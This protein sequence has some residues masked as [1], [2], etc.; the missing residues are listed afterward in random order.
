MCSRKHCHDCGGIYVAFMVLCGCILGTS[1]MIAVLCISFISN[2]IESPAGISTIG[3]IL[4]DSSALFEVNTPAVAKVKFE[5]Y[6]ENA[7]FETNRIPPIITE[8]LHPQQIHISVS[9]RV[10]LVSLRYDLNYLGSYNPIYLLAGSSIQYNITIELTEGLNSEKAACLHLFDNRTSFNNFFNSNL[11]SPW[12]VTASHC[13]ASNA[14]YSYSFNITTDGVYYVGAEVSSDFTIQAKA[15]VI[16]RRYSTTGL[17]QTC[18]HSHTCTVTLCN[19]FICTDESTTYFLI[20][21]T[22]TTDM[23]HTFSGPRLR[24]SAY[25]GFIA[26]TVLGSLFCC[27]CCFLIC[28]V[29]KNIFCCCDHYDS[30]AVD[31]FFD[32][33]EGCRKKMKRRRQRFERLATN[34]P[35]DDENNVR[36]AGLRHH[37]PVAATAPSRQIQQDNNDE[38]HSRISH[39]TTG[40]V[41]SFD[42]DLRLA[43]Y[44]SSIVDTPSTNTIGED[45]ER[46]IDPPLPSL[47][48]IEEE[49]NHIELSNQLPADSDDVSLIN[50]S[51][52]DP[53]CLVELTEDID[54]PKY[55]D[56]F[57][58]EGN[59]T[60]IIEEQQQELLVQHSMTE[61]SPFDTIDHNE[62]NNLNAISAANPLN[63]VV[64]HTNETESVQ[65]VPLD[66]VLLPLPSPLEEYKTLSLHSPEVE[67]VGAVNECSNNADGDVLPQDTIEEEEGEM[68][69]LSDEDASA[70][71]PESSISSTV[72]SLPI[73]KPLPSNFKKRLNES[74]AP[75]ILSAI[76]NLVGDWDFVGLYLGIDNADL[77]RIKYKH[78]RDADRCQKE[79]IFT[80]LR[81]RNATRHKLI[82]AL[83]EAGRNDIAHKV[84]K[85]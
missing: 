84:K 44:L 59:T 79:M 73:Y 54:S 78:N 67:S 63:T 82:K 5:I 83:K 50:L 26:T 76:K 49:N 66:D 60:N 65:L 52:D 10:F 51:R 58:Q 42:E 39:E 36:P 19:T 72:E 47:V 29:V 41:D 21:P 56:V 14:T 43:L 11:N 70:Y 38:R 25:A 48:P 71:T 18:D 28:C 55:R 23:L 20:Q 40:N 9:S 45:E 1:F 33:Y 61:Q 64:I 53:A 8:D 81:R 22:N 32:C 31:A 37:R 35:D 7:I 13:F 3:D 2:V 16:R 57:N 6:Y 15:S 12:Q 27:C 4:H 69:S 74:H 85:L 80:W 68:Q 24:G 34:D 75:I 30:D 17:K 77:E 62:D 46:N